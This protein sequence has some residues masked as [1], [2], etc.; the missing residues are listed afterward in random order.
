MAALFHPQVAAVYLAM[1]GN[2]ARVGLTM[3]FDMLISF[4]I[5]L[6]LA[7]GLCS[8]CE[9]LFPRQLG[10]RPRSRMAPFV[11]LAV[12]V[13]HP[14]FLDSF[15]SE[16]MSTLL[17]HCPVYPEVWV[18]EM[19]AS[20]WLVGFIIA[21]VRLVRS[22][23]AL[24]GMARALPL[25]PDSTI[26][27]AAK[28]AAGL[29]RPVAIRSG[30]SDFSVISC[31]IVRPCII[32]PADFA[33][34]YSPEEQY[35]ILLHECVHLKNRDTLKL[36]CVSLLRAVLWFDPVSRHAA[37]RMKAD[38]ELLCDW[39]LVNIHRLDPASYATLIVKTASDQP[40]LAPGFSD[41]YRRI[42]GRLCHI[43]HDPDL[44]TTRRFQRPAAFCLLAGFV[45]M[46]IMAVTLYVNQPSRH[47]VLA[48]YI[49][50]SND[51]SI[52]MPPDSIRFGVLGT[53]VISSAVKE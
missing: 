34:R 4:G 7:Y 40:R 9:R 39:T 5:A 46:L 12:A 13:S 16:A 3:C 29:T 17:C 32:V 38:M 27:V 25:F 28:S 8:L 15:V 10:S 49:R 22:M 30:P 23:A 18:F 33:M 47:Q 6:A 1:Y 20:L 52:V 51:D 44:Q 21:L 26:A 19:A 53:Y 50:D 35:M 37:R 45:V 41:S 11:F 36:L 31:G 2:V 14:F 48:D 24:Q 43:L 42:A